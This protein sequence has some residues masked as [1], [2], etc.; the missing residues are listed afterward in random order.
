VDGGVGG[1]TRDDDEFASLLH[2]HDGRAGY[3]VVRD[4]GGQLSNRGS[5]A[6]TDDDGIDFCR[7]RGGFGADVLRVLENGV[8]RFRQGFRG[9]VALMLQRQFSRIGND[10]TNGLAHLGEDLSEALSVNRTGCSGD[11]D[12]DL[13]H[14]SKPVDLPFSLLFPTDSTEFF[15]RWGKHRLAGGCLAARCLEGVR[16]E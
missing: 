15:D 1:F 3:E 12:D 6:G 11:A 14:E 5:R 13:A 4:A 9:R 7:P 10:E 8:G 16:W 2:G